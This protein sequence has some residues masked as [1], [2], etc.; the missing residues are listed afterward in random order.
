M[1]VQCSLCRPSTR[2][3]VNSLYSEAFG[4]Q[5]ASPP[6]RAG[7]RPVRVFRN[8]SRKVTLSQR[9]YRAS[10]DKYMLGEIG[11]HTRASAFSS[12]LLASEILIELAFGAHFPSAVNARKQE[13]PGIRIKAGNSVASRLQAR[14]ASDKGCYRAQY[15]EH[16]RKRS[17]ADLAVWNQT[18]SGSC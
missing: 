8:Y 3:S 16:I 15:S 2:S 10:G 9:M 4:I 11:E 7:Q 18:Y 17:G 13:F 6:P 12:S 14:I 5:G 1:E